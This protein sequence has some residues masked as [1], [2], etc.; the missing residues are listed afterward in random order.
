MPS[1]KFTL[2][3]LL[4]KQIEIINLKNNLNFTT[5]THISFNWSGMLFV[6]FKYDILN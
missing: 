5:L 2:F 3:A 6:L 1:N 4:T